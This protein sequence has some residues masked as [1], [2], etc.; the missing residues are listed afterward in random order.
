MT[1]EKRD[2]LIMEMHGFLA[3]LSNLA[4]DLK[5][6]VYGNG[7]PGLNDRVKEL[8]INHQNCRTAKRNTLSFWLSVIAGPLSGV[9]GAIVTYWLMKG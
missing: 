7:Q 1:N 5:K 3:S 2:E 8:E 9:I 6:T 4:N